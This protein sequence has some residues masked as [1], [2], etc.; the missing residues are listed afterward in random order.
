[1]S[2]F[3]HGD[4]VLGA[5]S[6]LTSAL[7]WAIAAILF[8]QLGKQLNAKA[9]NLGKGIIALVC[10][11]IV[12]L[13]TGFSEFQINSF[14][15]LALSGLLGIA[16]GDTLYFLTLQRLGAKLTLLVGTLIPVVTGISAI[17]L[18]SET[19][20]ILSVSGLIVTVF[21][22]SYVLWQK[23]EEKK[24]NK[25]WLS[26]LFIAFFYIM[27]ES[28]GILLTKMGLDNYTSLEATFIRQAWGIAGLFFWGLVVGNLISDFKPLRHNPKLLGLFAVTSFIGAFLG[29]WFSILAL[30]L[31]FASVAVALNSTSPLFVLPIA[32]WFL[33]EKLTPRSVYGAIIA[34]FGVILYFTGLG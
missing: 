30:E 9:L 28:G 19:P 17:I 6:A 25:V 5:I 18:F 27:T 13:P 15:F 31:T 20:S 34:V 14:F 2:E 12:L 10:L 32:Y 11:S 22:V 8:S 7:M 29:T 21:G 26:G 1:M 4:H 33:K 3:T 23:V 16:I 24:V